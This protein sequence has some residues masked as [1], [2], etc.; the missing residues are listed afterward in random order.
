MKNLTLF[1][2]VLLF[3]GLL[4]QV[5]AQHQLNEQ[6]KYLNIQLHQLREY[7]L[8]YDTYS[9]MSV[10]YKEYKSRRDS[11]EIRYRKQIKLIKFGPKKNQFLAFL[12]KAIEKDSALYRNR[13]GYNYTMADESTTESPLKKPTLLEY[14]KVV[15]YSLFE[16]D[17][18]RLLPMEDI[19]FLK[20]KL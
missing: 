7:S 4:K 6:E 11:A 13:V 5:Q 10:K 2:S 19:P 1:L 15:R 9:R 3:V 16:K 20:Y 14:Y 12:N 18:N 17:S 8:A